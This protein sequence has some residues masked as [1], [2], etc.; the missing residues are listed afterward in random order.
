MS[1]IADVKI[2]FERT[3]HM[4]DLENTTG[5]DPEDTQQPQAEAKKNRKKKKGNTA[6]KVVATLLVLCI[7]Y[8]AVQTVYISD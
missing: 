5:T 1:Y 7:A 4:D 3:K 2:T 8:S 6:L